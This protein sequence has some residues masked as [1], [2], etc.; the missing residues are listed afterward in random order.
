MIGCTTSRYNTLALLAAMMLVCG[1]GTDIVQAQSL[2][3]GQP[4][5]IYPSNVTQTETFLVRHPLN[6]NILF[7]SANT[8]NL[9]TGFI[10]EGVYVSTNAGQ[11]WMGNDTCTGAPI[12]FHRGDPAIVIDKNGTFI[13]IRLGFSPGLYAHYSTDSGQTWSGQRTI[14][15]H[16]QDR[17]GLISD[18]IPVSANYGRTYTAWV[19]LALPFPVFF[20]YTDD[21]GANWSTPA[22]V[23]SPIQRSQG[24]ELTIGP[25]GRVSICWAAVI[26]TSPFTED[27]VGFATSTNG[28]ANWTVTENAFDVN[29]IQGIFP[30]MGNIRV[31]GLP[32]I[33]TDNTGG[34]RNGW[35]Y[36]V[37]TQRN[38]A[39]AGSDP[40]IILNRSSNNG[41]TWSA[42][43]RVNQDQLNN[44]KTQFFPAIHVDDSGDINI[45]Y[46]DNR[47][48][49]PD[50]AGMYLSRSTDGGDTW[51]DYPIGTQRFKP[52]PIGGLGQGYQGDN[53]GM[54]SVGT[55]LWPVWM[56][57]SSGIY[58]M[59]ACPIDLVA[60]D[61]DE[62]ALP[63]AFELLQNYPN[64]FN[65]TTQISF[66]LAEGGDVT[67]RIYDIL[68]REVS[69]LVDER[70]QAGNHSKTFDANGLGGGV[71]FYR[72]Q[73][74]QNS[75]T[76]KMLLLK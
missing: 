5:R 71:Y 50:S 36:I 53:I 6:S 67:L 8:I 72:L 57:N 41:Q 17:A 69:T 10:S 22:Q 37:T 54:T 31:N 65:P 60:L 59:W 74:G 64:P 51:T 30:Q 12:T 46:Y 24:A 29:G 62:S 73:S 23:N 43:I 21:G 76:R 9:A 26:N 2:R 32:K 66:R 33:D 44:G 39:P 20:S 52:T 68:G 15:T 7:G 13:L 42:G 55:T 3:V 28:G 70:L 4:F 47:D 56:D 45:I 16:D 48:T 38:L 18:I 63:S 14:S 35:I 58:Q 1:V 49:T 75:Q 61:V 40:D 27:F 34:P 25:N 19:R 11:T